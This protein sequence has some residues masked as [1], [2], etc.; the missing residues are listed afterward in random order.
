MSDY[1]TARLVRAQLET[2]SLTGKLPES[3][4]A[5][6]AFEGAPGLIFNAPPGRDTDDEFA[7]LLLAVQVRSTD[8][9]WRRGMLKWLEKQ[10]RRKV[11]K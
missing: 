10:S 6:I 1:E 4:W 7:R 11:A 9:N 2:M 5:L 3:A 8:V